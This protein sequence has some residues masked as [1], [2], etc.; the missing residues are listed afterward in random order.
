MLSNLVFNRFTWKYTNCNTPSNTPGKSVVPG[1]SD[2]EGS[3]TEVATSGNIA[4]DVWGILLWVCGGNTTATAKN[5]LLDIGVDPAGGTDYVEKISNIV[6]GGAQ[7]GGLG[8]RWFY[9][10]YR[11]KAGSS[12]AVR[13]QGTQATAGTVRVAMKFYGR[14]TNPEY[15]AVG[16]YS[17]TIGTITGSLGVSFTPGNSSEGSWTSLGTTTRKLWWWQ[18]CVQCNNGTVTNLAYNIDLAY[19]DG[20]NYHMIIENL[21]I[22]IGGTA[23]TFSNSLQAVEGFCEVPAGATLYIR[24]H[25]SGTAVTGWNAVAV[26]IGG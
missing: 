1:A 19:G 8:G 4:Y 26:G 9:F 6:C 12:I 20:T 18:L 16:T 2:V 11:V 5:H 21:P 17:E 3:W 24:G 10:P 14:P 15:I 22:Q 13:I 25:C 23:E 7:A